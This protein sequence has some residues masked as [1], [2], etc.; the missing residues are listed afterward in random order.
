MGFDE[1]TKL[2]VWEKASVVEDKDP[3]VWRKDACDALI[4]YSEHGKRNTLYGWEIDH[5]KPK[6]HDG[7]DILSNLRP[8][9]WENNIATAG[10]GTLK[11]VINADKQ[12]TTKNIN[13]TVSRLKY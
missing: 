13:E 5:I 9:H 3:K 2:A 12:D 11:C 8:L 7:E 4:K 1:E 10:S 6:D